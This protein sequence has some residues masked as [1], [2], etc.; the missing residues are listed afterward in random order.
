MNVL[1]SSV[2]SILFSATEKAVSKLIE[3][4]SL[5]EA[6]AASVEHIADMRAK[7]KFK[8]YRTE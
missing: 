8:D 2:F 4:K 7:E 3:T 6:L 1:L 5:D